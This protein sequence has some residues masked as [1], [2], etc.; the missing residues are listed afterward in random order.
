M[1]A[2]SQIA[3]V[4]SK[5]AHKFS[6]SSRKD[7][8]LS[9]LRRKKVWLFL[10]TWPCHLCKHLDLQRSSADVWLSLDSLLAVSCLHSGVW[11]QRQSIVSIYR[12]RIQALSILDMLV[13]LPII[14]NYVIS[15]I[16]NIV[17]NYVEYSQCY[18]CNDVK[19]F[20]LI[21]HSKSNGSGNKI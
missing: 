10:K 19:G 5:W 4:H 9:P 12:D 7:K 3:P 18:V 14:Y 16:Y 8:H 17:Y 20:M 6:T 11:R 2:S 21:T 15:I 1:V 13:I